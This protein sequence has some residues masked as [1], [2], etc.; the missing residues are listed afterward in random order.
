MVAKKDSAGWD[1][2]E[3]PTVPMPFIEYPV[4]R[5]DSK[6]VESRTDELLSYNTPK[7]FQCSSPEVH[8]R[9]V[10]RTS[11]GWASDKRHRYKPLGNPEQLPRS[12]AEI[13]FRKAE[14]TKKLRVVQPEKHQKKKAEEEE[15]GA[16]A[17]RLQTDEPMRGEVRQFNYVYYQYELEEPMDLVVQLTAV[18]GDPDVF[19]SNDVMQPKMESQEHTWRG[20]DAGDDEVII[21][22]DHPKYCLGKFYIG[23]YAVCDSTFDLVVRLR[24]PPTKLTLTSTT[25]PRGGKGRAEGN[26][27]STLAQLIHGAESRRKDSLYGI[28]GRAEKP[29]PK[30]PKMMYRE[31]PSHLK[32]ELTPKG[33]EAALKAAADS[34][35]KAPLQ[36]KP[37][38]KEQQSFASYS[39]RATK[40]AEEEK[41]AKQAEAGDGKK[42]APPLSILTTPYLTEAC[43]G[44]ALLPLRGSQIEQLAAATAP[45]AVAPGGGEAALQ[46]SHPWLPTER[47]PSQQAEVETLVARA[48]VDLKPKVMQVRYDALKGDMQAQMQRI[49]AGLEAERQLIHHFK[50]IAF[51]KAM[52]EQKGDITPSSVTDVMRDVRTSANEMRAETLAKMRVVAEEEQARILAAANEAA[53]KPKAALRGIFARHKSKLTAAA[54]FQQAG[55]KRG[56]MRR[57]SMERRMSKHSTGLE[58]SDQAASRRARRTRD[59]GGYASARASKESVS[60]LSGGY[61]SARA[62]KEVMTSGAR[63]AS[64]DLRL[65]AIPSAGTYDDSTIEQLR[66][67]SM[68]DVLANFKKDAQERAMQESLERRR[69]DARRE[70][71]RRMSFEAQEKELPTKLSTKYPILLQPK[72]LQQQQQQQQSLF[73][74]ADVPPHAEEGGSQPLQPLPP[75]NAGGLRSRPSPRMMKASKAPVRRV[76]GTQ[77]IGGEDF[78]GVML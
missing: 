77:A 71:A 74:A 15:P 56:S 37:S 63:R 58:E 26:G 38:L 45:A 61:A 33:A 3:R 52:Q 36:K 11:T 39:L 9:I 68:Q 6:P 13:R 44:T 65:P 17:T 10:E 27:Y 50:A 34:S 25:S 47:E 59:S 14:A 69:E 21:V 54:A 51:E 49:A 29:A 66:T 8:A 20:S 2:G 72:A 70:A 75:S 4:H 67:G 53:N 5:P 12:G 31:L 40:R 28:S 64:R 18:E 41:A 24:E 30:D 48:P 60:L 73:A 16:N 22:H 1:V 62:S 78:E 46:T 43:F 42:E 35:Q 76:G 7:D 57:R 19:I 32:A 55:A 23:V